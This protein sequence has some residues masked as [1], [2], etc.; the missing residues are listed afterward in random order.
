[1]TASADAVPLVKHLI[2]KASPDALK[3]LGEAVMNQAKQKG[4]LI[5]ASVSSEGSALILAW[6]ADAVVKSQG[7]KAGDIVKQLAQAC[8]GGGGG[9]PTFAQAGGK[10]GHALAEAVRQFSL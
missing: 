6:V 4:V 7:V 5:L 1:L 2:P 10:H 9:K 8:G 3:A